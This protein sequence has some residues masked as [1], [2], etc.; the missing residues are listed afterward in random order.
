[1]KLIKIKDN[2]Y[3]NL[4][5]V[6]TSAT[7]LKPGVKIYVAG[8]DTILNSVVTVG[9]NIGGVREALEKALE[10][11]DKLNTNPEVKIWVRD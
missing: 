1:M 10:I 4:D 5:Q 8:N 9:P 7:G 3:G 6:E 11:W 2:L